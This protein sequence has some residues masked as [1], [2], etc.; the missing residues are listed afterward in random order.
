MCVCVCACV[1]VRV[2]ICV[3]ACV[4]A[5]VCV[6]HT[7]LS[8]EVIFGVDWSVPRWVEDWS[9]ILCTIRL[10]AGAGLV[11]GGAY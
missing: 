1:C 2:C 9:S 5:C 8:R 10:R 7:V 11:G 4:C 6:L 3:C